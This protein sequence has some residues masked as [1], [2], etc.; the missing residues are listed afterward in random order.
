MAIKDEIAA[1]FSGAGPRDDKIAKAGTL[2]A[3]RVAAV[4]SMARGYRR[5]GYWFDVLE[6][7]ST[8][9][10]LRVVVEIREANA[11]GP[12]IVSR[13][14]PLNPMFM[15]NPITQIQT[16]EE[17]NPN[18]NALDPTSR[19]MRPVYAESLSESF[20]LMIDRHLAIRLAGNA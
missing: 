16:G 19:K 9:N 20:R 12:L 14:D 15:I 10:V 11:Q 3:S 7:S 18:Y 1:I 6:A 5:G 4:A 8:S 17:I 13:T 2:R